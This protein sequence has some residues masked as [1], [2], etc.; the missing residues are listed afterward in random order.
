MMKNLSS[1]SEAGIR[2]ILGEVIAGY[3]V[4]SGQGKDSTYPDGTIKLQAAFFHTFG[5]DLSPYFPGT[6][7]VDLTPYK[8]VL[9]M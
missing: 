2:L 1:E 6:L 3:G 7:N 4:A 5:I 9:I 8:P